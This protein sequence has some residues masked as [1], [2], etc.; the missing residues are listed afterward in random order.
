MK[1]QQYYKFKNYMW[2]FNS[3]NFLLKIKPYCENNAKGNNKI[4]QKRIEMYNMN[5]E[6]LGT[7]VSKE[8]KN[9][10]YYTKTIYGCC[11]NKFKMSQGFKWKWA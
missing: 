10:G 6:L 11:N 1:Q 2:F 7:Y 8:L 4:E 9:M 3:N 5:N